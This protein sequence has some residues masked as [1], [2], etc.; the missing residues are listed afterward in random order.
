M[1]P[2][3]VALQVLGACSLALLFGVTSDN[4]PRLSVTFGGYTFATLIWIVYPAWVMRWPSFSR[5]T[6]EGLAGALIPGCCAINYGVSA[7]ILGLDATF[8]W[9]LSPH[10]TV[11][12]FGVFFTLSL[13]SAVPFR[14][15]VGHGGNHTDSSRPHSRLLRAIEIAA[16]PATERSGND[17][18]YV[19]SSTLA[20]IASATDVD[21]ERLRD[22]M[23]T[24]SQDKLM[25]S[26]P[27]PLR[28]LPSTRSSQG[29]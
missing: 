10:A 3:Y 18:D 9:P 8:L 13:C 22:A 14:R 7:V 26:H 19:D 25:S 1:N 28:K 24:S 20:A 4:L 23:H 2:L 17:D 16:L 12:L 15:R 27:V 21:L 11:G 6:W 5:E 29:S